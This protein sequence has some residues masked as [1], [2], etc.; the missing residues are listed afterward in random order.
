MTTVIDPL[1]VPSVTYNKSGTTIVSIAVAARD[2]DNNILPPAEIPQSSGWRVVLVPT[3][4]NNCQDRLPVSA[5]VGDLVEVH[6]VNL[7]PTGLTVLAPE[8]Q[9]LTTPI[10]GEVSAGRLFRKVSGTTWVAIGPADG[11]A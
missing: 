5:I 11:Q 3:L 8:G 10:S 6:K 1:G 4:T 9:S 2:L 7:N